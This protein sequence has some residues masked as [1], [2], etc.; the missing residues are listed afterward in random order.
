MAAPLVDGAELR[1][2]ALLRFHA[3]GAN[4]EDASG[5]E[6]GD[7]VRLPVVV[8]H[9]DPLLRVTLADLLPGQALFDGHRLTDLRPATWVKFSDGIASAG[10]GHS[11]LP[12]RADTPGVPTAT[13]RAVA[14]CTPLAR[15]PDRHPGKGLPMRSLALLF[16]VTACLEPTA[17]ET[18]TAPDAGSQPVDAPSGIT[19]APAATPPGDGHHNAGANCLGCHTGTGAPAWTAAGTLYNGARTAPLAGATI[20]IVD[21]NGKSLSLVTSQNGNFWT[22]AALKMPLRVSASR[23]PSAATMTGSANGACNGCHTSTGSPGRIALP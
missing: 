12:A 22:T 8:D 14:A 19:C 9:D 13:S 3:R 16:V 5:P 4:R 7:V 23:C 10:A 2:R 11:P 17:P 20:T 6:L 21:A 18:G 15:T 1:A